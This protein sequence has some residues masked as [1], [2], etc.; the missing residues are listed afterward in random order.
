MDSRWEFFKSKMGKERS[1]IFMVFVGRRRREIFTGFL[2]DFGKEDSWKPSDCS[3]NCPGMLLATL[4]ILAYIRFL[5][6]VVS[7]NSMFC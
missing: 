5:I 6:L 1:R 4:W 7:E 2:K 3:Q